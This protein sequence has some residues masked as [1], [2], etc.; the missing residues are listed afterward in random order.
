MF[1]L[2]SRPRAE[3]PARCITE[4]CQGLR[5]AAARPEVRDLQERELRDFASSARLRL[6]TYYSLLTTLQSLYYDLQN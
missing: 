3:S 4:A 2:E 1:Y 5:L 6:N